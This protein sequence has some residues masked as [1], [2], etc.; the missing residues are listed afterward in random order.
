[1]LITSNIMRLGN[2]L[3]SEVWNTEFI[4]NEHFL[5]FIFSDGFI[6]KTNVNC[7]YNLKLLSSECSL[8]WKK[9]LSAFFWLLPL[10]NSRQLA[11]HLLQV[12]SQCQASC[13]EN[14]S[15]KSQSQLWG[16]P[17]PLGS[18]RGCLPSPQEKSAFSLATFWDLNSDL[19]FQS[20]ARM[21]LLES[22]DW[23]LLAHSVPGV[24]GQVRCL[25]TWG[26]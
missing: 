9:W 14:C 18:E 15:I 3:L 26:H 13:P 12:G 16:S 23:P 4:I 21:S 20:P 2:I 19:T 1:M 11:V 17:S 22:S 24:T 7:F 10:P 6:K 5:P 25:Q 8:P